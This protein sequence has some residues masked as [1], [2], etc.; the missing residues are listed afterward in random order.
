[1]NLLRRL[2]MF[3]LV[4]TLSAQGALAQQQAP[5]STVPPIS[6]AP[7][8][9]A[10]T[11]SASP[12][13]GG[14]AT[15]ATSAINLQE[16]YVLGPGDVIEIG[17]IGRSDF[18]GRVQVQ[19]DGTIQLPYINTVM[20]QNLT[21]L[22]LRDQIRAALI[23]GGYFADPAVQVTVASYASRYVIVLGEV[24]APGVLPVD[25]A[26]RVSEILARVGGPR[27]SASDDV[28]LTRTTGEV[29]TISIRAAATGG[30]DTDP[31]VNPGD[32]IY[33][34]EAAQFY[35]YGQVNAPGTYKVDRGMTLRMA[36]A[37]GGGLTAL[38]SERRVKI[39]RDGQEIRNFNPADPIRGGDTIVVGE[40]FF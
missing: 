21:V 19:T 20:A 7:P 18:S 16:G 31:Y 30:N 9:P 1:M 29:L 34:A 3:F 15:P 33:V 35:I 10:G 11:P 26:Y 24:G 4:A 2:T 39:F 38:G 32:K 13:T 5:V 22:Q 37:R 6:A 36:L 28:T 17:V 40:R 25:R 23:A 27:A 14:T 12:A 8:P